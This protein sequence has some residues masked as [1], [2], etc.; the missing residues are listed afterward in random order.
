MYQEKYLKYKK[1]Y[2]KL[3]MEGGNIRYMVKGMGASIYNAV[4]NTS[5]YLAALSKPKETLYDRKQRSVKETENK[6]K[7]IKDDLKNITDSTQI[8]EMINNYIILEKTEHKQNKKNTFYTMNGRLEITFNPKIDNIDHRDDPR[9]SRNPSTKD[10]SQ[11]ISLPT[12]TFSKPNHIIP[13]ITTEII[14]K[15]DDEGFKQ[16]FI[17][18]CVIYESP[19]KLQKIID[20]IPMIGILPAELFFEGSQSEY[21]DKIFFLKNNSTANKLKLLGKLKEYKKEEYAYKLLFCNE[22]KEEQWKEYLIYDSFVVGDIL[23]YKE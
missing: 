1:K 7:T 10:N 6:L 13:A 23:Y 5:H 15:I 3:K 16:T 2:L 20:D 22:K 14:G 12:W 17:K 19:I 9:E 18:Q 21:T 8:Y 4:T 11:S